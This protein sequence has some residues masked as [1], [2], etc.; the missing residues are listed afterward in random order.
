MK[1]SLRS[2]H[3]S[4]LFALVAG[5]FSP[6]LG[7][8]SQAAEDRPAPAGGSSAAPSADLQL[9]PGGRK[10][11]YLKFAEAT[12]SGAGNSTASTGK[13]A[14]D[15][16]HTSRVG[17]PLSGRVESLLVKPGDV[18]KKGQALLTIVSPEVESAIADE[19][20]AAAEVSLQTRNLERVRALLADQAIAHKEVSQ[21]ESDLTKA[22]A[23]QQRA[24]ARLALLGLRSDEHS[25]RFTLRAPLGGTVVERAALPGSEVRSDAGTP[26]VTIS[27]L[28]RVWVVADIYEKNVAAVRAGQKA[29][30]TVA[31]YPGEIFP[32]QIEHVGDVVDAQTRTVKIRLV[33]DN[34]DRKLKPE[35]FAR[36]ALPLAGPTAAVTVPANAV[37]S[38][39]E[40]N[41]VMVAM[42]DG[43][44]A[45]RRVEIGSES[46]GRLAVLSGLRPGERVVVDG[47][48]FLKAELE[49]R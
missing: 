31:S 49:N 32:A 40:A 1:F 48:L 15:E 24:R 37:L 7:C 14:F 10:I 11:Q 28:S 4:F 42:A 47:A 8:H 3:F 22:Q 39:G 44:F 17:S 41:V 12:I 45:K 25:S 46:E 30:V 9:E 13:I 38:D 16:D 21:A 5:A 43:K 35:M 26:L 36:V 20:A 6:S 2:T 33:A 34:P 23:G 19:R 29:E 18:V 27:D